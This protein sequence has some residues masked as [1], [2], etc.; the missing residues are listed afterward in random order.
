M[1]RHNY[2]NE[3]TASFFLPWMLAG[4]E[5][6]VMG[7]VV[8]NS[9]DGV[10]T[11]RTLNLAVATIAAA[12]A[13]A[14]IVSFVWA[15]LSH[16]RDKIKYLCALQFSIAMLVAMLALVPRVPLGLHLLI[17]L[18]VAARVCFAG[19]V[20]LRSTVWAANYPESSRARVTGRLTT[21]QVGLVAFSGL[22]IGLAM[23][24]EDWYFRVLTPV[25]ALAGIVGVLRYAKT[26]VRNHRR[27]LL[28]ER[29]MEESET[30]SFNPISLWR[31]LTRD[32]LFG[33]FMWLQMVLGIGNL[34]INPVLIVML[35]DRFHISYEGII[36]THTLPLIMMPLCI[37]LWAR[38]MDRMHIVWFRAIHSWTFV[39]GAGAYLAAGL[40]L[41]TELLYLGAV[42]RGLAFGGGALAWSLGHLDFAPPGRESQYMSVHVTLTGLRGLIAPILGIE[43]YMLLEWFGPGLGAWTFGL[44]TVLIV[45]GAIGFM[46]LGRFMSRKNGTLAKRGGFVR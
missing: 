43:V 9:F 11:D 27:L 13:L 44:A 33:T 4:V 42:F 25:F 1:S 30:P 46:F 5:G 38:L 32:K 31:V 36:I 8:K 14:N 21:I 15:R 10:V 37:P 23:Q 22:T 40:L 17:L 19:V 16:G 34:M 24:W 6:G 18:V 2:R 45:I 3:L 12:P 41:S 39:L 26:R 7:V 20:T 29:S 35:K 28:A